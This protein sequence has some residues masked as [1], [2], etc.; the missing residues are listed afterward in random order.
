LKANEWFVGELAATLNVPKNTLFAWIRR[1]WVRVVGQLPGYRGRTI[2][3]SDSEDLE[4]LRKLRETR[5]GWW[6]PPL[7]PELTTPKSIPSN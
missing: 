6:D 5:H 2:C 1:G 7:P 3:W 4:R